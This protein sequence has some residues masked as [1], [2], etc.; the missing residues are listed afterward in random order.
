[1][2]ILKNTQVLQLNK[3]YKQDFTEAQK[4]A[5]KAHRETGGAIIFRDN[6]SVDDKEFIFVEVDPS[7]IEAAKAQP[8]EAQKPAAPKP[9][10]PAYTANPDWK[11][12]YINGQELFGVP[13]P[14]STLVKP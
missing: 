14:G 3:R 9:T 6:C 10:A 7:K 12:F 13:L 8:T 4:A 2:Q 1:M 11:T 5:A